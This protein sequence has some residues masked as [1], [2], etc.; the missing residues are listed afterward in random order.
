MPAPR[1]NAGSHSATPEP[2]SVLS[3]EYDGNLQLPYQQML[4][5]GQPLDSRNGSAG[6]RLLDAPLLPHAGGSVVEDM[7]CCS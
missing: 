1:P 3:A 7:L 5:Y 6:G 4:P 2:L